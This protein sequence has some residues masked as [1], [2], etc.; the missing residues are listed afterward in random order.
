MTQVTEQE[1][2][3]GQERQE[4]LPTVFHVTHWKAGSQWVRTILHQAAGKRYVRPTPG[5]WGPVGER[6]VAGGVYTPVYA[7][8]ARGHT[9][10]LSHGL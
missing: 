5:P 6:V 9:E 7:R 1:Q 4:S 8:L 2:Q 10:R 3:E